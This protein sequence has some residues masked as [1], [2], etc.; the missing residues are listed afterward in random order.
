MFFTFD[1]QNM[2]CKSDEQLSVKERERNSLHNISIKINLI[3][4]RQY[5]SF[6]MTQE[7]TFAVNWILSF[8]FFPKVKLILTSLSPS[9]FVL[10]RF[11]MIF[12]ILEPRSKLV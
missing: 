7:P 9:F 6:K 8:S 2:F 3:C 11:K 4:I 12:S 10:F 1:D 5:F